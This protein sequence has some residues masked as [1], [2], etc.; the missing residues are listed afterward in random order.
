MKKIIIFILLTKVTF[1]FSQNNLHFSKVVNFKRYLFVGGSAFAAPTISDSLVVPLN[2]VWKIEFV[3]RT[4]TSQGQWCN[5]IG[6]GIKIDNHDI[7]ITNF[8]G[9]LWVPAG[10]IIQYY[11]KSG[12]NFN[13]QPCSGSWASFFTSIIEFNIQ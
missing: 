1:S 7:D 3:S 12:G 10:S 4:T 13:S 9:P 11:M 8:N 5:P 6:G 2:K